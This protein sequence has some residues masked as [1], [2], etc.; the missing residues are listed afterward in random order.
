MVVEQGDGRS[1]PQAVLCLLE[2]VL[3]LESFLTR[4]NTTQRWK[5]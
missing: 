5:D 3:N 4:F 1:F 2:L